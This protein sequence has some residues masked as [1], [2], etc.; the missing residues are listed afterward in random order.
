VWF[1]WRRWSLWRRLG[2]TWRAESA[3][4]SNEVNDGK[5]MIGKG[6]TVLTNNSATAFKM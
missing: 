2:K 1:A 6:R 5:G 3:I 4:K